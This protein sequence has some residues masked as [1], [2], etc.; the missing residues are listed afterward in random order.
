VNIKTKLKR[1][2]LPPNKEYFVQLF[3][4]DT[5]Q[6]FLKNNAATDE[7]M[8][9]VAQYYKIE[10]HWEEFKRSKGMQKTRAE[11]YF[12][13]L[14]IV[15]T[16]SVFDNVWVSF[17][18]GLH[19]HIAILFCLE[20][21]YFVYIDNEIKP[22]TLT[23]KHLENSEIPYFKKNDR[24]LIDHL[25]HILNGKY[26]ADMLTKRFQ[27]QTFYQTQTNTDVS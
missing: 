14:M 24:K 8:D 25:E 13:L 5:F 9:V 4:D 11:K 7:G 20:C 19:C 15:K 2:I 18:K 21:S 23:M 26:Q 6:K 3:E 12:K 1:S 17:I 16:M 10:K 27:V 22:V